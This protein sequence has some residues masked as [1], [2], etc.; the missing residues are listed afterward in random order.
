LIKPVEATMKKTLLIMT[1]EIRTT[2]GRKFFIIFAFGTP[3]LLGIIMFIV[4]TANRGE[5]AAPEPEPA[6][7]EASQPIEGYV[8]PGGLV[9]LLPPD[10]VAEWI[11][12]FPDETSAAAA[13]QAGD[14]VGYYVV[15]PD[16]AASGN[17]TY[18]RSTYDPLQGYVNTSGMEWILLYNL[19]DGKPEARAIWTPFETDYQLQVRPG[20]TVEDESWITVLLPQLMALILY[21][22]ILISSSVLVQSMTDEKKNRILEQLLT[23][24]SPGQLI[25]G[26]FLGVGVLG[27]LMAAAWLG[28]LWG[29]AR[30]GGQA[31]GV[32][33]GFAIP[34]DLYVW[35]GVFGLLG[36][37]MYG[38]LLAGLG[39][40]AKDIKDTRGLSFVIML[41]MIIVYVF[42]VVIVAN[43]NGP[44]A[45]FVS[46]FPLMAPVGMITRM[47]AT[48][49]PLWQLVLSAGLQLGTA[50]LI[51]RLAT[52]FFRAQVL[53]SG[54]PLDMRR[55][56]RVLVG[57]I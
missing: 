48:T 24:V 49:V 32:P 36:F 41:P 39:A 20:A 12:E 16:Y 50:I 51:V 1:N 5:S 45:L 27:L 42:L 29:L 9:Q 44:I 13:L 46:F 23:S 43:P 11:R 38:A 33:M 52:H 34:T 8:D 35:A 47:T 17:L 4:I 6:P 2:L 30:Y 28:V 55:Y 53:L 37:A 25:T 21:M 57:R 15:S 22:V 26:K 14:I 40:V 7:V 19:M 3:L 18:V 54:Q 31:L 10:V 56:M